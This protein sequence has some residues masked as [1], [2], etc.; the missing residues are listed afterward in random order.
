MVIVRLRD[1]S[2]VIVSKP[3]FNAVRCKKGLVWLGKRAIYTRDI[4]GHEYVEERS[5]NG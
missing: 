3:R 2:K 4:I 1:G 5:K